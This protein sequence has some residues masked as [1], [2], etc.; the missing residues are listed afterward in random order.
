MNALPKLAEWSK[1]LLDWLSDLARR[2]VLKGTLDAADLD[3]VE[4]L[5]LSWVGIPDAE[6]RSAVRL[7]G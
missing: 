3:A 6:N 1:D 4:A 5:L 2:A 7:T